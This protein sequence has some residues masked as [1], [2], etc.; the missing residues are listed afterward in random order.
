MT[1]STPTQPTPIPD[2]IGLGTLLR[3]GWLIVL[4]GLLLGAAAGALIAKAQQK[5]YTASASVRVTPTGVQDSTSLANSRTSGQINLDT[6][7]QLTGVGFP[8]GNRSYEAPLD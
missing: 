2:G 5:Q 7:A 8:V 6:E 3:R 4:L 1:L